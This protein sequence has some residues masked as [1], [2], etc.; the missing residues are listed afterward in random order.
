MEE[1]QL[2]QHFITEAEDL[3]EAL[4]ADLTRLAEQQTRGRVHPDLLNKIFRA[5]H[6]M[7]GMAGLAGFPSIQNAA[8]RFE[9]LLD[10]LRMGRF[11][12]AEGAITTFGQIADCFSRMIDA[13]RRGQATAHDA[14][15]ICSLVDHL[16]H[17]PKTER[18]ERIEAPVD[19][20]DHVRRTFTEY[21]EHRL[22]ENLKECRPI[23]DVR[24]AFDLMSFDAEFRSLSDKLSASGEVI[25]TLPGTNPDNPMQIAFRIIYA[26]DDGLDTVRSLVAGFGGETNEISHY[27]KP[28]TAP[29]DDEEQASSPRDALAARVRVPIQAL[30]DMATLAEGLGLKATEL[31][32]TCL[33]L[34]RQLGLSARERF[35]LKQQTRAI[36]RGF[37]ELEELLVEMRLVPLTQTFARARRLALKVAAELGKDVEFIAE[38]EDTRLDKTIVDRLSDPLGHLLHNAVDHGIEDPE[39]RVSAG[40]TETGRI[41]LR[42]ESRGNRVAVSISDDGAGIDV[43]AVRRAARTRDIDPGA[44]VLDA[45]FQPGVST[46]EVVSS[47]SGR[48]VGLDAAAAV[49]TEL[50]GEI[51]VESVVGKGTTFI[52]TLPTTV[53]VTS[54]F[55]VE[56]DGLAYAIDVN[57]IAELGLI[58]PTSIEAT[59]EGR[60][61][62]W[63]DASLPLYQLSG[64]LRTHSKMVEPDLGRLQCLI[65]GAGDRR[66]AVSVDRFLGEREVVVKSCGAHGAR[67]RFVNGAVDIEGGRVA[68]LL[69]LP[70]LIAEVRAG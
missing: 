61:A 18:E 37:R 26:A 39:D 43:D 17:T 70:S 64:L 55:F 58:P 38:G 20:D 57:Q 50:G 6:S 49:I 51:A 60:R 11:H 1:G 9:D 30:D 4:H 24:V 66:A 32:T 28:Q 10:D 62:A 34:A 56:S 67:L 19:L 41:T 13:V 69:D 25:S 65:V 15:T 59:P 36:Q 68:L 7:K 12:P 3:T 27:P 21:E 23:Y 16:R 8:H 33:F 46:A 45:I 35:D 53:V 42:A 22:S 14:D 40:K 44:R 2:L 29:A 48:G 47:I 52:L 31:G 54:V 5:A 63:R